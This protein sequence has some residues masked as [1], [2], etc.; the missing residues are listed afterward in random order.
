MDEK[1]LEIEMMRVQSLTAT[2]KKALNKKADDEKKA[3][4]IEAK[5]EK[6]KLY[7]CKCETEC[8]NPEHLITIEQTAELMSKQSLRFG[9]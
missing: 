3:K 7:Y 9:N 4:E 1:D 6:M 2:I 8:N 5:A